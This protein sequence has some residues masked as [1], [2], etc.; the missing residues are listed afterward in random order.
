MNSGTTVKIRK[1]VMVGV[2]CVFLIPSRS[3]GYFPDPPPSC[4]HD[5]GPWHVKQGLDPKITA[6]CAQVPDKC[7]EVDAGGYG[8]PIQVSVSVSTTDGTKERFDFNYCEDPPTET[9]PLKLSTPTVSWIASGCG[10]TPTNGSG[11]TATFY[12]NVGGSCI[13]SFHVEATTS[14]CPQRS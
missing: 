13:V 4:T 1:V 5:W 10:A 12:V 3:A 6:T 14:E 8:G 11:T 2:T 9:A 7:F